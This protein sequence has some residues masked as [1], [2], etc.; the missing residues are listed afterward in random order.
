MKY[1]TF[2]S[3][4]ARRV[5]AL[6]LAVGLLSP[7][8]CSAFVI[9]TV[10][11][12]KT[13]HAH[14]LAAQVAGGQ[15]PA[16]S[17][18]PTSAAIALPSTISIAPGTANGLIG[19]AA[20]VTVDVNCYTAFALTPNYY[21]DFT[22]LAGQLATIDS[23]NASPSGS[24]IMFQTNVPGIDVLLTATP[25]QA[26]SGSNGP[27]G[28]TGWAVQTSNCTSAGG[29]NNNPG[30][31]TPNPIAA[32]FTAQLVKTGPVSPGTISSIQLLQLF[33]SDSVPPNPPGNGPITTYSS[34]SVSFAT[35]T[36]NA[37]TVSMSTCSVVAGSSNLSVTLPTIVSNALPTTGSVAGKTSFNIQ[38]T[39]PSG[40]SLYM[41]MSTANPGT[42]TGV[43]LPSA[44][45]AAGTPATNVGI[46]LL[47][48][49]LQ[50]VQFNTA[51]SVG[52]SPNG[53]LT[54]PYYAQYYATGSPISAGQV[55]GTA[56]FTMS[57]Q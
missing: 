25:T 8:I 53:K 49:N 5:A 50:A 15:A 32:K 20:S 2:A 24:G 17:A 35:V 6:V 4:L 30:S 36:L 52:N 19:S 44:T 13:G 26:S 34:A 40:W 48:S 46:Q 12:G 56:T 27:N 31:C 28:T 39:C 1:A 11:G 9:K 43:I 55:C 22:V 54:L 10:S 18:T 37:I 23:T 41:T 21:D 57:Y 51:Q 33:D 45:C 16:C 14:A 42:A 29:T 3:P 38:Y 47:Q 7:T